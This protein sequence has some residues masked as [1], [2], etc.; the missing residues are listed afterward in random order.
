MDSAPGWIWHMLPVWIEND[1]NEYYSLHQADT[2]PRD[3]TGKIQAGCCVQASYPPRRD[4]ASDK[5]L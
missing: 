4:T 3:T 1:L 2:G 5:P